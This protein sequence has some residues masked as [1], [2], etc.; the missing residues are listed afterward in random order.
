[1]KIN[2][3]IQTEVLYATSS[4]LRELQA[5]PRLIDSPTVKTTDVSHLLKRTIF[6]LINKILH[7]KKKLTLTKMTVVKSFKTRLIVFQVL[8]KITSTDL[9][10]IDFQDPK[11]ST[12]DRKAI[13][14]SSKKNNSTWKMLKIYKK[15]NTKTLILIWKNLLSVKNLLKCSAIYLTLIKSPSDLHKIPACKKWVMRLKMHLKSNF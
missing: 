3:F 15:P 12:K 8:K 1:M 2:Q 10:V 5:D 4:K 7:L 6:H 9:W 13:L 14:I 11:K